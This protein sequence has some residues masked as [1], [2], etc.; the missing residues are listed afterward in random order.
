VPSANAAAPEAMVAAPEAMAAG[1][2]AMATAPEAMAEEPEAI[3]AAPE[4]IT[5][6][7]EA[8]AAAPEALAAA[9]SEEMAGAANSLS[10]HETTTEHHEVDGS[11][12]TS[13]TSHNNHAT[14]DSYGDVGNDTKSSKL[15]IAI[16]GSVLHPKLVWKLVWCSSFQ[17]MYTQLD[18]QLKNGCYF[19]E[20]L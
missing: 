14:G 4:V 9:A 17:P 20:I 15:V 12:V 1:P 10:P 19:S 11:V 2:E 7:P 6:A 13:V 18:N 16:H 3:I 8:M 5:A